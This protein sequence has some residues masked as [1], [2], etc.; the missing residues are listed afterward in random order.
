MFIFVVVS[1][2][3]CLFYTVVL[4]ECLRTQ[5]TNNL[6]VLHS[7]TMTINSFEPLNKIQIS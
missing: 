1:I 2:F 6:V 3:C 4:C 5:D 7:S